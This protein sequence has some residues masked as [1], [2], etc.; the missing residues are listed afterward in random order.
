[1]VEQAKKEQEE[2]QAAQQQME[3]KKKAEEEKIAKHIQEYQRALLQQEQQM[4]GQVA[5]LKET[6]N[7]SS[8]VN[9]L[10]KQAAQSTSL[11]QKHIDQLVSA[12]AAAQASQDSVTAATSISVVEPTSSELNGVNGAAAAAA[13]A[14]RRRRGRP[15]KNSNL[16]LTYSPPEKRSRGSIDSNGSIGVDGGAM[17]VDTTTGL[18]ATP[19]GGSLGAEDLNG[20]A[21][22][23]VSGT[24]SSG[25]KGIRNRVFCGECSGCLKN[26]DCGRCR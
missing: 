11:D 22:V 18:M 14:A 21:A 17:A 6:P 3:K 1:M 2:K 10:K 19:N 7:S 23:G 25:G 15:P 13:A 12:A 5:P 24:K 4:P 8:V 9:L 26:D 20:I 16:D